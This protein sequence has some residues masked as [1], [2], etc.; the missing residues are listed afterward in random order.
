VGGFHV[1]G[2]YH[3]TQSVEKYLKALTLAI[4]DP[5]GTT[6][7][8]LN[9]KWLR[10]HDL[11]ELAER[12]ATRFAY[13][14][15][16]N[17]VARLRR[18]SEFDQAARYPWIVQKYGNGFSS[19]DIPLF[20]EL[21]RHLRTDLPIKLDDYLLGMLIRGHHQGRPDVKISHAHAA[22]LSRCVV[23]LRRMFPDVEQIVR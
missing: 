1:A 8:A 20:W 7:T 12:C 15:D 23:A 21:I 22:G 9:N 10:T 17:I 16:P 14:A 13:Y 4:I 5:D 18:F 3:A 11:V 6:K 2:F 19:A